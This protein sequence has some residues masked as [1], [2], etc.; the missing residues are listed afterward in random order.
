[1]AGNILT[2]V[3]SASCKSSDFSA[4]KTKSSVRKSSTRLNEPL[5]SS[6]NEPRVK[7]K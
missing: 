7:F 4:D 5:L 1:M 3:E 2:T 6:I